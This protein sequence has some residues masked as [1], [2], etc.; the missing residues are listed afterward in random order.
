MEA[1]KR[2]NI[3]DNPLRP[4]VFVYSVPKVGSTSIVSSLRLFA[5]EKIDI[6]HVHDET[7]L[8]VLSG[9]KDL[10]VNDW[11][12]YNSKLGKQVYVINVYRQPIERKMSTFFEKIGT[13][14]FNVRDEELHKYSSQLLV[15]RFNNILMHIGN[16]DH[17]LHQYNIPISSSFLFSNVPSTYLQHNEVC[18][19][20][21]KYITLRLQD[22]DHWSGILSKWI[23]LKIKMVR[24]YEGASKPI[25]DIY[26]DFKRM[27]KIPINMLVELVQSPEFTYYH[28]PEE[29]AAYYNMWVSKSTSDWKGYSI[30]E[31]VLYQQI[32]VDNCHLETVQSNHYLDEGCTCK[33]CGLKR[34]KMRNEMLKHNVPFAT[35]IVHTNTP[36]VPKRALTLRRNISYKRIVI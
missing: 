15:Q 36:L 16:G 10:T 5:V 3:S 18:H 29:Q 17:W 6:I 8:Q 19:R 31:Y 20:G 32:S 1:N 25:K 27:Y 21:V 35:R 22:S 13:F 30:D 12:D 23:G 11:I 4:I 34:N 7:M 2:L 24:D 9:V 28:S 26:A 33:A 14:H